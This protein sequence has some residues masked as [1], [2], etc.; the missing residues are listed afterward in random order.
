MKRLNRLIASLKRCEMAKYI[1]Q[2]KAWPSFSWD[3]GS[4]LD[5]LGRARLMQGSL[6]GSV[7]RIGFQAGEEAHS[8]ILAEEAVKTSGIEGEKLNPQMVR[9]SVARHLGLKTAGL[10]ASTRAVDGLV[11]AMLDAVQNHGNPLTAARLKSWHA[12]LFPT[13]YSGLH[14][15]RAGEWRG[16]EPMRVVSGPIGR[17]RIHFEAPPGEAIASE[18]KGFF[19]W[20]KESRGSIDGILRAGLAHFYFVTIHPF[21]DGNGRLARTITDMAL[22]Q[23][24]ALKMRYYSLSSQI[25]DERESYYNI[26][27]KVS[28][29]P[30]TDVTQWLVWFLESFE[31]AIKKSE[32]LLARVLAK[33]EF[34]QKH[35]Q[36]SL[37]ARQ[38]KAINKLLDAG[39]E[40]FEGGLTTRKYAGMNTVSRATAFREIADMMEKKIL[41]PGE[42]KGRNVSYDI[43]K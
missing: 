25:I 30:D 39:P 41:K 43:W 42:G 24:E 35:S 11:E 28:C 27:E 12:A 10:I 36:D 15:I 6:L 5:Y 13:G 3:K 1:W 31:R 19:K 37:N 17:E 8:E 29:R 33:A 32:K 34:W 20:W 26:L 23:D 9:S 18:M 21:E 14:R 2:S 7:K 38:I 4:L 22:A 16:T 40:G